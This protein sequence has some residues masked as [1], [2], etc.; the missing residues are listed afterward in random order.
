MSSV[1]SRRLAGLSQVAVHAGSLVPLAWLAYD[2]LAGNLS[3]NPIQEITQ[4]TGKYALIL[5]VLSLACTP[6]AIVTGWKH[7]VRWRRPL[8][9]YALVYAA[10]H[11]LTFSGL[12]YGF[13]LRAIWADVA[14]KRYIFAGASAFLILLSLAVTSTEGWQKRLGRVWR[15]LHRWVYLAGGLVVIHYAWAVK[16]DIREPLA[17]GGA[18]AVLLAI[19]LPPVR[20]FFV[21]LR[22]RSGVKSGQNYT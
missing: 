13:D 17:W 16:S 14:G 12:D 21:R 15:L 1:S 5:L 2:A 3:A 11:F 7:A 10:I 8:G 19:R 6:A 20:R 18:I 22:A 9:V 4:R